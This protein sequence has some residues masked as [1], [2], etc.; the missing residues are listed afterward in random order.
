MSTLNYLNYPL[1]DKEK[2]ENLI[3]ELIHQK[4]QI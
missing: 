4:K 3:L 1:N 2:K